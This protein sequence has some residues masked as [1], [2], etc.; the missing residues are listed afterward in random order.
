MKLVDFPDLKSGASACEFKS[1]HPHQCR[2]SRMANAAV[3]GTASSGGSSPLTGTK[4]TACSEVW[5]RA[6]LG[7]ERSKVQILLCRPFYR[8]R[9]VARQGPPKPLTG[10]RFI[11]P[12]PVCGVYSSRVERG[13][14]AP[15]I[16]VR[17]PLRTPYSEVV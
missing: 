1:H 3:L 14:V 15:D 6:P 9:L 2:C 17:V 11:V 8:D 12:V 4:L 16:R 10:V 7:R 13:I 5:Y